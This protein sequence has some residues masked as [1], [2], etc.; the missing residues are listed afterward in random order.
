MGHAPAAR[1]ARY[2]H[3]A[4][5]LACS[6]RQ[7]RW[8]GVVGTLLPNRCSRGGAWRCCCSSLSLHFRRMCYGSWC[9]VGARFTL[10]DCAVTAAAAAAATPE[11]QARQQI[12]AALPVCAASAAACGMADGRHGAKAWAVHW[13]VHIAA[14]PSRSGVWPLLPLRLLGSWA[15]STGIACPS[16]GTRGAA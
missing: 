2:A 10:A 4:G 9:I 3:C 5:R 13:A 16:R 14:R 1:H 8:G 15:C 11:A 7:R 6:A 12:E